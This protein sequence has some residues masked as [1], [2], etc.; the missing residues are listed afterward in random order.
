MASTTSSTRERV[1]VIG[2]GFAGLNFIKHLDDRKFE[3]ILVDRNNFHGFPPLFYQVASSGLDPTSIAFPFRRELR[4]GKRHKA[5]FHLGEVRS[6]D[7]ADK[8]VTTNLET[9]PYDRLVIAAGSTNNFFGND[10]LL[11]KVYTLKSTDEAIRIRNEMLD[12]F[13]RAS[14]EPDA[15]KRRRLLS[16]VVIG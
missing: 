4:S 5:E 3:I 13:E 6:I 2:G 15:E 10:D 12:R 9:I 14:V 8:T 16:F 11:K 7:V 1:V